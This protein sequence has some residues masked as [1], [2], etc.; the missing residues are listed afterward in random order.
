VRFFLLT[1]TL[2]SACAATYPD[3]TVKTEQDAIAIATR[4]CGERGLWKATLTGDTWE[5]IWKKDG[6]FLVTIDARTGK[7]SGCTVVTK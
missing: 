1:L 3:G 7:T 2:L 5:V 6:A 4:E